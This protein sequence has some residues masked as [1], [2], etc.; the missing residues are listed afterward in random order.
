VLSE[1]E[2]TSRKA[3]A[4]DVLIQV[5]RTLRPAE[6]QV[7]IAL[8]KLLIN[9][10]HCSG[11]VSTRDLAEFANVTRRN[12]QIAL[13]GLVSKN[14]IAMRA[15]TASK[16]AAYGLTF[17]RVR[18]MGG[19]VTTPPSNLSSGVF[20]TPPLASQGV[21]G[22]VVTTPPLASQG[23]QGG[24]VTTPPP[25]KER[26]RAARTDSIDSIRLNTRS[27]PRAGL[28]EN[29]DP[30]D[31]D[32]PSLIER[33]MGAK[34]SQ[35]HQSDLKTVYDEMYGFHAKMAELH[36]QP[37]PHPP[38]RA[39]VAQLLTMGSVAEI[40]RLFCDLRAERPS[41]R[42]SYGY[43]AVVA[44]ERLHKIPPEL[45]HAEK[46]RKLSVEPVRHKASP[47]GEQQQLPA[48]ES[49]KPDPEFSAEILK[50][51]TTKGQF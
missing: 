42:R 16:A 27:N 36:G 30:V 46:Q 8:T 21:Q 50:K 34:P 28:V 29:P 44:M 6:V 49:E 14:L 19:V 26:A 47:V 3:H 41:V 45:F 1:A 35:F 25:Y 38:D 13:A 32:R 51:V 40:Q 10:E 22:G 12:V 48:L 4:L 11:A 23:V 2:K 24:V 33:V 9:Q 20:T 17:L 15:G 18:L 37:Q 39:I 43:Y 31:F 5:A 7:L